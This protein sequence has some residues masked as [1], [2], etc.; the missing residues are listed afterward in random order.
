[1]STSVETWKSGTV[2]FDSAIR[3]AI[4]CCVRDSS[5]TVV[6]PLPAAALAGC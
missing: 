1:M 3:R 5:S 2:A 4:V 6:S